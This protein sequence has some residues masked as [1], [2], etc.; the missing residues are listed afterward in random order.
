MQLQSQ[1]KLK[2]QL[3]QQ[4]L[5]MI[6]Y[7]SGVKAV[8]SEA[9]EFATHTIFGMEHPLTI[10]LGKRADP[11]QD[12]RANMKILRSRGVRVVSVDRGGQATLHNPGQLVIY[13]HLHL[14]TWG[15]GV[16]VF[17]NCLQLAT[18]RLLHDFGIVAH[19]H[20]G[21]PGLYTERG[22]IAFF[23]LRIKNGW[24]SHGV[25]LNVLNNVEDFKLIRPC[26]QTNQKI[27][28]IA[29]WLSESV[30]DLPQLFARWC[31]HFEQI[32]RDQNG[33]QEK[34]PNLTS[35]SAPPML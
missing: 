15:V 35:V 19:T 5:G 24:S 27:C 31:Q 18:Q 21:E 2:P 11:L 33:Q 23:G 25:A 7:I 29:D 6:D 1:L 16:C 34:T 12:I 26:G 32:L 4:W 20:S 13:P 28:A 30:S 14:P 22:K 8:D 10:T 17:V 9:Q 3:N